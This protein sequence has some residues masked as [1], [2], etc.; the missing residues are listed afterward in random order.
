MRKVLFAASC[1]L[2]PGIAV[3]E[4]DVMLG[5]YVA[6]G[7]SDKDA[8]PIFNTLNTAGSMIATAGGVGAEDAAIGSTRNLTGEIQTTASVDVAGL[9]WVGQLDLGLDATGSPVTFKRGLVGVSSDFGDLFYREGGARA[10]Y[11]SYADG[12]A[13]GGSGV[14]TKLFD[15]EFS[16]DFGSD[17]LG[18]HLNFGDLDAEV[19]YDLDHRALAGQL[20]YNVGFTGYDFSLGLHGVSNPIYEDAL[21]LLADE[22][23]GVAAMGG[24]DF[25]DIEIGVSFGQERL[26]NWLKQ[27]AGDETDVK[28]QFASIGVSYTAIDALKL[29]V[30]MDRSVVS[31]EWGCTG[32]ESECLAG[33]TAPTSA[34]Y[35]DAAIGGAFATSAEVGTAFSVGAEYQA[36]KGVTIGGYFKQFNNVNTL[37]LGDAT[38]LG[39]QRGFKNMDGQEFGLKATIAF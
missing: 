39:L 30:D 17:E 38:A 21:D 18:Y 9:T 29:S 14:S 16:G 1:L 33:T 3:A 35:F 2:A 7:W 32:I 26:T 36:A 23:Y 22:Y 28:R 10:G 24:V 13:A 20:S 34:S 4:V 15:H 19:S 12:L 8:S 27:F 6:L 11:F 5:G 25:G 37:A 31:A